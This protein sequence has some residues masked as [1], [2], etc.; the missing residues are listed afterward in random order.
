[1]EET[2]GYL[3]MALGNAA[4]VLDPSIII[5]GG[6]VGEAGEVLFAPLRAAVGRHLLP[7]MPALEVVPA[8]LGY[9]AGIAGALA[10]AL[11]GV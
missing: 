6:G 4:N 11:D 8:A 9:D 10:L 1:V 3:G 2:A 7:S 5:I